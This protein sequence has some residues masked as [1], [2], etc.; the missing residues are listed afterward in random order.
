[1]TDPAPDLGAIF[2]LVLARDRAARTVSPREMEARGGWSAEAMAQMIHAFGFPSPEPDEPFFSED[3]AAALIAGAQRSEWWPIDVQLEIARVW[4]QSLARIAAAEVYNFRFGTAATLQSADLPPEEALATIR[5]ALE[6]LLPLADP[7]ILGLHRRWVEYE[8]TQYAVREAE[9]RTPDAI[10]G[11]T[12]VCLLFC[13]LKDFTAFADEQGDEAAAAA[14]SR[15]ARV[16]SGERGSTG[17][18]VKG[19]GDG[20]MLAYAGAAEAVEAWERLRQAMAGEGL[21]L[22][23]A[24]HQGEVVRFQG[25]YFG[26]AVNLASRLLALSGAGELLGTR[27][28]AMASGGDARWKSLG[29]RKLRGFRDRVDVYRLKP[30]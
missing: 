14:A 5:Q 30:G 22:H 15:F 11:A 12:E 20:A 13:D 7:L 29:T 27:P 25:D 4:G 3:E 1:M 21:Q 26:S 28:A 23:G 2:D 19:L 16:A 18:V 17:H 6:E 24:V 10:A 9:R 8:L